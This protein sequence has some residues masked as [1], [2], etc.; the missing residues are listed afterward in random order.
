MVKAD[1]LCLY[2]LA[3]EHRTECQLDEVALLI[4]RH[5]KR[6]RVTPV[7][8]L[9]LWCHASDADTLCL[10]SFDPLHEVHGVILI[11]IRIEITTYP[12]VFTRIRRFA[13]DIVHLHPYWAAPWG[14]HHFQIRIDR[15]NL[16]QYRND[17]IHFVGSKA[18][19]LD[20]LGVNYAEDE[21]SMPKNPLKRKKEQK[22]WYDAD[23]HREVRLNRE[24]KG[25]K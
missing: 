25:K 23:Q 3:F 19:I 15:Q 11:V 7:E 4:P 10:K 14:T 16:F 20:T 1:D 13:M 24:L 8:W 21:V 5:V 17:I 12:F 9:V 18:E 2:T 22:L 6:H